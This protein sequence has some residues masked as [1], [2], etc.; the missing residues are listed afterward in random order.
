MAG[1]TQVDNVALLKRSSQGRAGTPDGNIFFDVATRNLEIIVDTELAWLDAPTNSV[2]NTL[3]LDNKPTIRAILELQEAER[4]TDETFRMYRPFLDGRFKLGKAFDFVYGGN[5]GAD[6]SRISGSGWREFTGAVGTN[7]NRIY[8]NVSTLQTILGTSQV[9]AQLAEFGAITD[10][11]RLGAVDETI[12]V[13]G[14]TTYGDSTAGDF[15]TR[16]YLAVSTSTYG[17]R[18]GRVVLGDFGINEL[19]GYGTLAAIGESPHPTTGD[20]P[21]ADVVGGAQV[22]P[23]DGLS[24]EFLD[25]AE[26]KS[27]FNEA[28]GD[29][30]KVIRNTGSASLDQVIAWIDANRDIDADMAESGAGLSAWNGKRKEALY[31]FDA[32]GVPTFIDGA[33]IEGLTGGDLQRLAI[34]D[35]GGNS[36]TFPFNP[37]VRVAIGA[38]ARAYAS[39]WY[40]CFIYDGAGANDYNTGSAVTLDDSSSSPVKGMVSGSGSINFSIPYDTITQAGLTPGNDFEI[41]FIVGSPKGAGSVEEESTII[42]VTRDTL[43]SASIDPKLQSNI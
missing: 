37:E 11:N 18:H 28:D 32:S 24:F 12:Q 4:S 41:I 35:D 23:F 42:T 25:T 21:L 9:T 17:Q 31:E 40:H 3:T 19:E 13:F 36:K 1:A 43:I 26:T 29:F 16:T 7:I 39:A 20:Y 14:T 33:Y 38:S 5:A 34:S 30:D 27:G 22:A 15:D 10:F 6:R 8:F 2:P